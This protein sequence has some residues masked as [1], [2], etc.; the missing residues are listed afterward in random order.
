MNSVYRWNWSSTGVGQSGILSSVTSII[1][2]TIS[3]ALLGYGL[4]KHKAWLYFMIVALAHGFIDYV[5]IILKPNNRL[6]TIQAYLWE[7]IIILAITIVVLWLRWHKTK[8]ITTFNP[9]SVVPDI[10]QQPP[11][12]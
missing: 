9:Q 4:T 11:V 3:T 7:G 5:S 10:N 12:S 6:T 8:E 1:F 2:H